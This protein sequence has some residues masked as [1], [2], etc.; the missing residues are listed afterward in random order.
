LS[1]PI[2]A[3]PLLER[4]FD[5]WR[6]HD[7]A[8]LAALFHEDASY[9]I[10][11]KK[12]LSGLRQIEKYWSRNSAR[13]RNIVVHPHV[14][15]DDD[16][17]RCSFCACF[18]DVEENQKQ[19]V[20]G[21]MS[22]E[23]KDGRIVSLKERYFVDRR[24]LVPKAI[25]LAGQWV[26]DLVPSVKGLGSKA[27][28]VLVARST[29][30]VS[31]VMAILLGFSATQISN[32]PDW[33]L[34][35]LSFKASACSVGPGILQAEMQASATH[36]LSLLTAIFVLAVPTLF[37]LRSRW[38]NP[39]QT[40][41]LHGEGQ[42]LKAMKKHFR[43][44]REIKIYAGDFDFV[45]GDSEFL[46]IFSNLDK[47]G[48]LDLVS[49]KSEER[50]AAGFGHSTEAAALLS[51]LKAKKRIRFNDADQLRCSIIRRWDHAEILYRYDH[52]G[53]EFEQYPH[54]MCVLRG[55]G[56]VSPVVGLVQRLS[57]PQLKARS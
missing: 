19:T 38:L 17:T 28:E 9:E 39:V 45:G 24:W 25:A 55:R 51:S 46:Q 44:A 8:G 43:S 33:V 1:E 37:Q 52:A 13:Q 49:D 15:L 26:S 7:V 23:E 20:F 32:L 10:E 11:G 57:S 48:R 41:G 30:F 27:W 14:T 29:F 3:K 42:D 18:E 21:L 16:G 47:Q 12:T 22:I 34:C 31:Y 6:S 35:L 56:D 53:G 2:E 4:Y 50:V 40:I 54:R 36:T 5:A